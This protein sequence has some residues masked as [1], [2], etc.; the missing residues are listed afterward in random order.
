MLRLE[1]LKEKAAKIFEQERRLRLRNSGIDHAESPEEKLCLE[2]PGIAQMQGKKSLEEK[3]IV[4]ST[5]KQD[6]FVGDTSGSNSGCFFLIVQR[7]SECSTENLLLKIAGWF[8][9]HANRLH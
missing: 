8:L 3:Y 9:S 7:I 6:C 2:S 4:Q 5:G 1:S